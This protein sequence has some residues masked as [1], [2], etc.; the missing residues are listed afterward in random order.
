MGRKENTALTSSVKLWSA[1]TV[2]NIL[3]SDVYIG[4]LTQSKYAKV[5]YKSKNV[6]MQDEREWITVENTHEA[7]ISKEDF[8]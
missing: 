4:N 6:R 1:T 2:K 5:S 3:T 7:I 8:E